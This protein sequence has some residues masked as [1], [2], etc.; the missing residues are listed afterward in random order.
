[1]EVGAPVEQSPGIIEAAIVDEG[2]EKEV[3]GLE[4]GG[5]RAVE[6]G[7][8]EEEAEGSVRETGLAEMV[9]EG[10]EEGFFAGDLLGS[11][12]MEEGLEVGEE[13]G[14]GEAVGEGGAGR[15]V[16]EAGGG[17]EEMIESGGGVGDGFELG[18][19]G[20]DGF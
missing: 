20:D 11:E 6:G 12:E 2:I 7:E 15:V 9:D 10:V 3:E 14:A 18:E 8:V 1:M 4:G 13:A 16:V 5:G 19:E 17:G